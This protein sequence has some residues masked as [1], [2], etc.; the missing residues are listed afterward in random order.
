MVRKFRLLIAQLIARLISDKPIALDFPG[1]RQ[2]LFDPKTGT[3]LPRFA[4]ADDGDG[5]GDG[6]GGDGGGDG[7]GDDADKGGTGKFGEDMDTTVREARKHENRAKAEKTAREKAEGELEKLR[8]A[9]KSA[10]EKALDKARKEAKAEAETEHSKELREV[11]L[12]VAVAK[13]ARDLA[14][15]DDVVLN[16]ERAINSGELAEDDIFDNEGK[17]QAKAL[18]KALD[19]LLERKPHLKAGANGT[20]PSG[21]AN[22]GE[23]DD[24]DADGGGMNA[25]IRRR[26]GVKS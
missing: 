10:E 25:R 18:K 1:G 8:N 19:D 20:R 11:R 21:N 17:V 3:V 6:E 14:D 9:S 2:L 16:I 13:R 4:G 5:D 26:A 7:D 23:G 15:V 22:G 12:E 24:A